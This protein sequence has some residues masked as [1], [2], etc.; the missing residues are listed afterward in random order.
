MNKKSKFLI[1]SSLLMMSFASCNEDSLNDDFDVAYGTKVSTMADGEMIVLGDKYPNPYSVS[2]MQAAYSSLK[3]MGEAI[4]NINIRATD[5]Y[6]RFLPSNIAQY[7]QLNED[8]T[9][10]LFDYPLDREI[11]VE[12]DYYHDPKIEEGK[13]TWLYTTVPIDYQFDSQI[14]YEILDSCYIAQDNN[15]NIITDD[16]KLEQMSFRRLGLENQFVD[17][18]ELGAK[19][20]LSS[21][22][23]S[24]RYT[25]FDNSLNANV[26]VKNVVAVCHNVVKCGRARI[27]VDGN[28]KMDKKFHTNVS[29]SIKWSNSKGFSVHYPIILANSYLGVHNKSGYSENITNKNKWKIANINNSA[30]EYYSICNKNKI[31]TPPNNLKIWM[32]NLTSGSSAP[33]LTRVWHPIGANSSSSWSNFFAN[34]LYG[35]PATVINNTILKLVGPDVTIGADGRNV[36]SSFYKVVCHELSH[37]SHFAQVGSEYWAKYISFIMTYGTYGSITDNNAGICGVGEMWGFAMGNLLTY[38]KYSISIP[39]GDYWFKWHIMSDLMNGQMLSMKDVFDCLTN[40]VTSHATLKT[41][42]TTFYPQYANGINSV[43][44]Y[45]GF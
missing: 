26:P 14:K 5:L 18:A 42:L 15:E 16:D 25:F 13:Y 39:S 3:N 1:V 43:F 19:G 30:Y 12:G 17:P 9:L 21:K 31:L 32:T 41:K 36:S 2:N 38:N 35:L 34:I 28:Y 27:G 40:D 4:G 22:K 44:N 7:N 8:T 45:Y 6:V 29:Y 23:P 37:S 33:M 20:W 24:G 11:L 10:V